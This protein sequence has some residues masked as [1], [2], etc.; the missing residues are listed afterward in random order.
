VSSLP[1]L[2]GRAARF[3][4]GP[5]VT[6]CQPS[7]SL[8]AAENNERRPM[9]FPTTARR[10]RWDRDRDPLYVAN[11]KILRAERRPCARCGEEVDYS[12]PYWLTLPGGPQDQPGCFRRRPHHQPCQGWH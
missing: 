1:N 7:T 5:D 12:A 10:D 9:T 4:G 2:Q 3:F 6:A 8:F 11:R